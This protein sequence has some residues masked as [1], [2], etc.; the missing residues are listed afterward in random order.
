MASENREQNQP[1]KV[2]IVTGGSRGIGRAI[3]QELTKRGVA[4]A[5]T[6]AKEQEKA[7]ELVVTCQQEGGRAVAYQA[8]IRDFGACKKVVDATLKEL[9]PIDILINNA[10]ITRDKLLVMMKPEECQEVIDTNLTGTFNSCKAVIFH[11][12]KRKAG[13]I[14]NISS[15]SGIVG[16]PGQVNYSAAKAGMI[17][18]TKALAKEVAKGNITVNAVAPGFIETD[19]Y[20][21]IPEN[22]R[23]ETTKMIPMGRPGSPAEV[24]RFVAYLALEAPDYITGQVLQIDG[25]VA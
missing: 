18:L 4:V 1:Q 14:I 21:A 24:A 8:D 10:G 12:M 23:Q 6:Y 7:D 22:I 2:A 16:L 9:G 11:F 13:R 19:M 17:G 3:V 15:V 25:G 5:F 20:R